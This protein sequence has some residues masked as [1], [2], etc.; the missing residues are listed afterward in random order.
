MG[1][2]IGNTAREIA[3]IYAR[4]RIFAGSTDITE[5]CLAATIEVAMRELVETRKEPTMA[6]FRKKPVVIEAVQWLKDGDHPN[7]GPLPSKVYETIDERRVAAPMDQLRWIGTLEG[8]HVVSPGDWIITG[9]KGEQYPIKDDIFAE[10][11]EPV[12]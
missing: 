7:V 4:G 8:G 10:T 5:A 2:D 9:V 11:Y 3:R 1:D 12:E 6:K